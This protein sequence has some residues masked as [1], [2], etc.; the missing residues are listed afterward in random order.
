MVVD[1]AGESARARPGGRR[2]GSLSLSL[3]RERRCG[4]CCQGWIWIFPLPAEIR[5]IV[6]DVDKVL[7]LD[8]TW[9]LD[10]DAETISLTY[11]VAEL[12]WVTV[13][14]WTKTIKIVIFYCRLYVQIMK[15]NH[16]AAIL[17]YNFFKCILFFIKITIRD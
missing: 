11:A 8:L 3:S 6:C 13:T 10:T 15:Q 16:S 5:P 7:R 1:S 9:R 14:Y 4:E 2:A 17:I 12:F